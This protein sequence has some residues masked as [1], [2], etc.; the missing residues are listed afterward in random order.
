MGRIGPL[1]KMR[2]AADTF[3]KSYTA[4]HILGSVPAK[5]GHLGLTPEVRLSMFP[6]PVETFENFPGPIGFSGCHLAPLYC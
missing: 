3:V 6:Y 2:I 1:R 5:Q 4:F